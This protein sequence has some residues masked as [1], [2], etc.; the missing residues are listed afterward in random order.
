M[1]AL[2][3][4]VGAG[5]GTAIGFL[6]SW[7]RWGWLALPIAVELGVVA[8]VFFIPGE[9]LVMQVVVMVICSGIVSSVVEFILWWRGKRTRTLP[10]V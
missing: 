8:L 3:C 1:Y 4:L 10:E 7:K 2:A 6:R 9:E 5:L